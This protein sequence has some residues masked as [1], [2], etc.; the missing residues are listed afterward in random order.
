VLVV[1]ADRGKE[2]GDVVIVEAIAHATPLPL[3]DHEPELTQD[4]KLL[5]DRAWVHLHDRGKLLDAAL[6]I[7]EGNEKANPALGR[8]D[9]H[10]LRDLGRLARLQGAIGRTV[11]QR[12]RHA[13]N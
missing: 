3:G 11:F 7:E 8:E 6:V 4:P 12:M 2:R 9:T 1:V 5:G 13:S 10:R